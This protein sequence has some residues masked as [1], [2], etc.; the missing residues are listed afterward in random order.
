MNVIYE[1]ML[2]MYVSMYAIYV[3]VL[4]MYVSYVSMLSMHVTYVC[5][6]S[7]YDIYECMHICMLSMCIVSYVNMCVM[8]FP[9]SAFCVC[10]LH[11]RLSTTILITMFYTT[12]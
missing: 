8:N 12:S 11:T 3:C 2:S 10:T 4:S 5:M 6:L 9:L 7:M 1:C